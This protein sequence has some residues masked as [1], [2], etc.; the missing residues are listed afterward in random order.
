MICIDLPG[1]GS[2]PVFKDVHSMEFM[3]EA[4]RTV[5][6]GLNVGSAVLVGHS[7]GGYVSRAFAKE[8][9]DRTDGLV[10]FHSHA[11]ADSP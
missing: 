6:D 11:G 7:M 5:L 1:H 2:T 10:L 9:K 8:N 4:V 3:A